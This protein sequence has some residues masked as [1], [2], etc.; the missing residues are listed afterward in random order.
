MQYF[1]D[2]DW[3]AVEPDW[4]KGTGEEKTISLW[5]AFDVTQEE[6]AHDE[7]VTYYLTM[8]DGSRE[9]V[10]ASTV[11][12]VPEYTTGTDVKRVVD[13]P[14]EGHWCYERDGALWDDCPD[15]HQEWWSEA[16][17]YEAPFTYTLWRWYDEDE[18]A[19]HDAEKAEQE[20]AQEE[21]AAQQELMQAMPD[22]V[23]DLSEQVSNNAIDAAT[24]MEAIA[25]LSQVVSDLVEVSNG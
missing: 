17:A 25:D 15:I 7:P 11:D 20:A 14:R 23:A 13:T 21:Q 24:L 8:P 1:F 19:A 6:V 18:Q 12:D 16:Q 9:T 2:S 5:A 3:N 10:D 22:A 4:D